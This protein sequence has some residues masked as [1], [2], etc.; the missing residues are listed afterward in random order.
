MVS[1]FLQK[2]KEERWLQTVLLFRILTEFKQIVQIKILYFYLFVY[3][4]EISALW[5]E[6]EKDRVIEVSNT[7][8][9]FYVKLKFK[10]MAN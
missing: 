4:Y 8:N 9:F 2:K 7:L 5:Y 6:Y 3:F 1:N 10:L